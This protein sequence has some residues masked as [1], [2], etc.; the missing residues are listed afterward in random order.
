MDNIL[1]NERKCYTEIYDLIYR[2]ITLNED[3]GHPLFK[4]NNPVETF[5]WIVRIKNVISIL[6]DKISNTSVER[7]YKI[8]FDDPNNTTYKYQALKPISIAINKLGFKDV[9]NTQH[10]TLTLKINNVISNCDDYDDYTLLRDYSVGYCNW[11]P[12]RK[13]IKDKF[14]N[15][16]NKSEMIYAECWAI[17]GQIIPISFLLVFL[18]EYLHFYEQ[19]NRTINNTLYNEYKRIVINKDIIN[20]IKNFNFSDDEKFALK[21][22]LY[23]LYNGEDIAKMG[24]LFAD[25]ISFDINS[26][27][28]F[29]RYK[30]KI[31]VFKIYNK[32]CKCLNIIK[33]FKD[34]KE[35]A[36]FIKSHTDILTNNKN[37]NIT[38]YSDEKIFKLFVAKMEDRL[39]KFYKK[40]I[41][42]TGRYIHMQQEYKNQ[43]VKSV[44]QY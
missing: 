3:S 8:E 11:N 30:D 17:K 29:N 5:D 22:L 20:D 36:I 7:T 39:N 13:I 18:H 24:N 12:A 1:L 37:V 41:R 44:K 21:E 32:L 10:S 14:V 19:Y 26:L 43:I 40:I 33:N 42:F 25:L 31:N 28:S 4:Y 6:N 34:I 27:S 16:Y 35:L 15:T 2:G 23:H 38:K 9:I